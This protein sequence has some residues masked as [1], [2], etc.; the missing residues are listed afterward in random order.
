MRR[1]VRMLAEARLDDLDPERVSAV[2]QKM[3]AASA[4][5]AELLAEHVE[6]PPRQRRPHERPN[7]RGKRRR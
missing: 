3:D 4:A 5:V 2:E 1:L 7:A 6:A